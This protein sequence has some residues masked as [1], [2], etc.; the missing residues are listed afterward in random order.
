[1]KKVI[2]SFWGVLFGFAGVMVLPPG[3]PVVG[4]GF[5]LFVALGCFMYSI[6]RMEK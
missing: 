5:L 1:M 3:K 2:A 6:E 4:A